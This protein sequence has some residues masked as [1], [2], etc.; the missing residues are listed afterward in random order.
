MQKK[1]STKRKAEDRSDG[2]E[3]HEKKTKVAESTRISHE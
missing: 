1:R 3:G 2:E